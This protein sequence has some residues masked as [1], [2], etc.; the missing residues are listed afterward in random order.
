MHVADGNRVIARQ[1]HAQVGDAIAAEILPEDKP[2]PVVLQLAAIDVAAVQ[3]AAEGEIMVAAAIA[4]AGSVAEVVASPIH[5]KAAGRAD[6]VQFAA[7]ADPRPDG[8]LVGNQ[9]RADPIKASREV[10]GQAGRPAAIPSDARLVVARGRVRIL[11]AHQLKRVHVL[12]H[13]AIAHR[14][15]AAIAGRLVQRSRNPV[16]GNVLRRIC[17]ESAGIDVRSVRGRNGVGIHDPLHERPRGGIGG[18][19]R[20][21]LNRRNKHVAVD[22]ALIARL[23]AVE[24]ERGSLPRRHP[25]RDTVVVAASRLHCADLEERTRTDGTVGMGQEHAAVHA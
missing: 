17:I 6:R 10:A 8:G 5:R 15:A 21:L 13:Q 7:D 14:D 18:E 11:A 9:Q 3:L 12:Q 20:T 22:L 25:H 2:P 16:V 24:R 19:R 4:Q 23:A 1:A